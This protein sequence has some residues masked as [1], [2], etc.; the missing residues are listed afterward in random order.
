MLA[1]TFAVFN[2]PSQEARVCD[3]DIITFRVQKYNFVASLYPSSIN[4]TANN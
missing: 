3:L 2:N 1:L 4:L